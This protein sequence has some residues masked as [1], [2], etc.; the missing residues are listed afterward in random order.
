M[1]K[2]YVNQQ[3]K[4]TGKIVKSGEV[5][6]VFRA[7]RRLRPEVIFLL[8]VVSALLITWLLLTGINRY[9]KIAHACDEAKGYTCSHYEVR[10]FS[11]GH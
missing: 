4:A 6:R 3:G 1:D 8:G 7:R 5:V 11:L 2:L 10:L 9:E